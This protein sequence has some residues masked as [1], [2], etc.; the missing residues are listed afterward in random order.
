MKKWSSIFGLVLLSVQGFSQSLNMDSLWAPMLKFLGTW[1]GTGVVDSNAG[2]YTR[3]Y[4]RILQNRF[5]EVRN[6]SVFPPSTRHPQ[7]EVH[8]D[9][10]YISYDRQ[11]KTF[12]LRQFHVEGFVNQ[13]SLDSVSTYGQT[14]RFTTT[15]IENIPKGF[16]AREIYTWHGSEVFTETFEIAPPDQDFQP[17]SQ[18][19]LIKK[20]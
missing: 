5:I 2:I 6:K 17:Y 10:G 3:S 8:E 11:Q 18:V 7:G 9:I 12:V 20:E 1:S 15:Q 4:T 13:Y 16:K 19:R 14:W